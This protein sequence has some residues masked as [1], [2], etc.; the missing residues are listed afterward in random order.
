MST[1][2]RQ[3]EAPAPWTVLRGDEDALSLHEKLDQITAA[4]EALDARRQQLEELITDLMPAVNGAITIAIRR[5][6]E[7]EKGGTLAFA[8]EAAAAFEQVARTV[9]PQRLHRLAEG[10]DALLRLVELASAPELG[11]LLER[12][13]AAVREAD[14]GPP[15]KLRH[16]VRATREPRVRRGLSATLGILRAIGSG[17]RSPAGTALVLPAHPP[18]PARPA[19]AARAATKQPAASHCPAPAASGG[20][21]RMP[22]GVPVA[23]D[24]EGFMLDSGAWTREIA[25][26]IAAEYGLA[27]LTRSHWDVIEFCQKDART[28]GASP[29]LRRITTS[30]GIAPRAMYGLF[31]KGPGML[32]ARIA[33]LP[34]PKSCV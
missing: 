9:E 8:R 19:R 18:A 26:A 13:V 10:A 25:Q 21:S 4:V 2:L 24:A 29:G 17:T 11:A 32:A 30:L 31:P 16:L 5:L 6:D 27:E 34:K 23:F 22:A 3:D 20:S 28:T 14:K 7:L 33:G 1:V 12:T 15:P